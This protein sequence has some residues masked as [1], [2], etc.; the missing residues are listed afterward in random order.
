MPLHIETFRNDAGGSSV[1]KALSHPLVAEAARAL[2]DRLKAVEGP[3]ALYDPEGLAT[4]FAT[5]HPLHDIP[6]TEYFVQNVEHLGR[7]FAGVAA[8]PV[9]DLV[10]SSCAAVL[11]ASFNAKRTEAQIR[12]LL[13]QGCELLTFRSLQLPG[14]MQTDGARYLS[15]LNFATNFAFFRDA[16]GHHTRLVTANYWTRYGAGTVRLWC[17]LFDADGRVL[18]TWCDSAGGPEA[19]IVIDSAE[20]RRR[21]GLPAFTGQLFVHAIGVAGHD[22]VKYALDTYGDTDDVLSATHDANSWPSDLY[23][24]LPAPDDGEDVV[25]W[26]QNSHPIPIPPREIG[27]VAMGRQDIAWLEQEIAPF[28]THRLSVRDLLPE[29]RWPGQIEIHAGK[30]LVRPRYEVTGKTGRS[31]IAHPNVERADLKPDPGLG[32]LGQWFEKGHIL[33][34][35][36]LPTDTYETVLQPTPMSTA[37]TELPV[38]LL[39]YS[40]DGEKQAEHS[41]GNLRRDQSV[42]IDVSA[43]LKARQG[44]GHCELTYDFAAGALA[45][46]WLHA[47]VRY[48]RRDSG[49]AAETSFGSHIFNS[50]LV[51]RGEPQSYSGPAPGLSTRLFLRVA[52]APAE[53]VCHLIYPVSARWRARSETS[54]ILRSGTGE[55]IARESVTIPQSG[56]LFWRVRTLFGEAALSRAGSHAYVIVR[57]ETCRLFGYHGVEGAGGSFSLDHMFGF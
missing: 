33:P 21:F 22:I 32:S 26:V 36:I 17:R 19:S 44:F 53:T 4:G 27:L 18:A 14:D 56:S 15:N 28:A 48:R 39:V 54:L 1:Y 23:A 51:Y 35:A 12:P 9:T 38:K 25:L 52:D 47:L 45:D 3:V 46:G 41:F 55:D 7:T 37:Q 2:I 34:A 29:L 40:A 6:F 24:G 31:R 50:A 49:H 43:F 20:V 5:F 11:A 8:R 42:A 16:D 10:R 30:H 13:P 57:D